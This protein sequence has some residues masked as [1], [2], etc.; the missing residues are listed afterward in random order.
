VT[1]IRQKVAQV[2]KQHLDATIG[3]I[4]FCGII[5]TQNN[6]NIA[7]GRQITKEM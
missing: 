2:T 1:D 7:Q 4:N 5:Q 3:I 6:I